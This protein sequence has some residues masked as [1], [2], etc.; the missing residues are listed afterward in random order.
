M[1]K[2]TTIDESTSTQQNMHENNRFT[3]ATQFFVTFATVEEFG[4]LL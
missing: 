4:T 3:L 2:A 1:I